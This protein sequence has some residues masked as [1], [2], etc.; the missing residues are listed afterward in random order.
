MGRT[1]RK[2]RAARVWMRPDDGRWIILDRGKQV[3]TGAR[4][5]DGKADAQEA[6]ERY[7]A[8]KHFNIPVEPQSLSLMSVDGVLQHYLKNL[9]DDI[10]APDRQLYAVVALME[11]WSRKYC[12][13]INEKMCVGY[14]KTRP[15]AATAR[16]ELGVLKAALNKAFD[17]G[18]IPSAPKV[19]LPP[20]STKKPVSLSRSEV[21]R[22]LWELRKS[23]RSK[24]AARFLICMF[25]TGSRP[26]TIA[27]STWVE[28]SDG[29]WVDL[30]AEI[31]WRAGADEPETA[32]MR[33]SHRI[34]RRLGAHL[35]RWRDLNRLKAR[36]DEEGGKFV[37][38]YAHR[39]NQPVKDIGGVL[40][41]ACERAKVRRITPHVL[42][43]TAITNAIRS[44]MSIEDAADYFSTSIQTIQDVYWH[45]SPHHQK[46]AGEIMDRSGK[47][48]RN[49]TK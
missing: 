45:R 33:R 32:K 8:S 47:E 23:I 26:G 14:R 16:R 35:R 19:H 28:R 25:Y 42:K 1:G 15:S 44:G 49:A 10:A 22:L 9:R 46:R 39:P 41:R 21:A 31:W 18:L 30:D 34:P 24:H 37:I 6:L 48:Q 11:F 5:S 3:A 36:G 13:D 38:E 29:P 20:K 2:P 43:H 40:E 17:D 27:Q 4:G 12:S 7:L